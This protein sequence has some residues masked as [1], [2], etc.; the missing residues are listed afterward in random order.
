MVAVTVALAVLG[1][2]RI[3]DLAFGMAKHKRFVTAWY[4]ARRNP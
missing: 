2:V 4:A 1:A 3:A